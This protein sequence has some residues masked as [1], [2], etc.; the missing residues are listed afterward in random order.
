MEKDTS[1]QIIKR[2]AR[3]AGLSLIMLGIM[4]IPTKIIY[5]N[6][7]NKKEQRKVEQSQLENKAL[8]DKLISDVYNDLRGTN[9]IISRWGYQ[10][11]LDSIGVKYS[12]ELREKIEMASVGEDSVIISVRGKKG[13]ERLA[14]VHKDKLREYLDSE[15]K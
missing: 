6:Y 9:D 7:K 15:S 11:L 10:K 3:D 14:Y 12:I 1:K 4:G 5:D 13:G 8:T 2:I